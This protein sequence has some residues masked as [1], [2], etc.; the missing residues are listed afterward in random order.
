[1]AWI[2]LP[3]V[4]ASHLYL[5]LRI[6]IFLNRYPRD[7]GFVPIPARSTDIPSCFQGKGSAKKCLLRPAI[8]EIISIKFFRVK[9]Y[10]NAEHMELSMKRV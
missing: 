7:S 5:L 4:A 3:S 8:L 6:V 1:M 2:S 9:D 10:R